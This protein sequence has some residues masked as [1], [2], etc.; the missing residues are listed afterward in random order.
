MQ[1]NK[2]QTEK[3]KESAKPLVKFLNEHCH[4]HCIAIV[5]TTGTEVLEGLAQTFDYT[6]VKD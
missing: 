3:L 2:D 6:F 4:P 1:L 5:S